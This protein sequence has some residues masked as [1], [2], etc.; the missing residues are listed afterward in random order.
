MA[1][2]YEEVFSKISKRKASKVLE[3]IIE[4]SKSEAGKIF[5]RL[6]KEL[7]NFDPDLK[8]ISESVRRK[9]DHQFSILK[10]KAYQAQRSRDEITRNQ[11]KRACINIYPDSKPQE[12]VFNVV[13]YLVLYGLQF[14]E[15]VMSAIELN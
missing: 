13:Q 11:I 15:N 4:S 6:T 2:N 8:N 14:I 3:E 12:R 1:L 5:E 10:E 9:V 7:S